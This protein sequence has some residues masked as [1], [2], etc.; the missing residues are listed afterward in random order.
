MPHSAGEARDAPPPEPAATLGP[1]SP[2]GLPAET[3]PTVLDILAERVAHSSTE[4]DTDIRTLL[5]QAA[6]RALI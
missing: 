4:P 1:D 3:R 5:R 2:S 6:F